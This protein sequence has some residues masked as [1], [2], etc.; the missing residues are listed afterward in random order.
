MAATALQFRRREDA[1]AYLPISSTLEYGRGQIVYGPTAG[2]KSLYL[3]IAGKVGISRVAGD[4]SEVL[5]EIVRPDELFGESGFLSDAPSDERAAAIEPA[6]LMTWP[7]SDVEDLVRKRPGLAVAL[8]QHLAQRNADLTH[9]IESL[10]TETIER[11]LAVSLIRFSDRLGSLE[12]D[13]VVRMIPFTHE[14][15]AK[16]VG[17]SREIV[18]RHMSRLRQQGYVTYS[19]RA[20]LLHRDA[21]KAALE[22]DRIPAAAAVS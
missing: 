17:T 16:Y 14:M 2:S 3:V 22:G 7:I 19:R 13:G 1:L 12:D 6:M 10:A 11:R 21:L 9:R 8:L 20:V 15:L 18:T 4:G 5:L